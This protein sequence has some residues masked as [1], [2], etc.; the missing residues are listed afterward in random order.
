MDLPGLLCPACGRDYP[1]TDLL[2]RCTCGSVLDV[3]PFAQ[4]LPA[5]AALAGR[6]QSLWRYAEVLPVPV[7]PAVTLQEGM[8]PLIPAPGMPG[9]WI[10]L[11]FLMP[12][13]SFKDRGAAVL[14]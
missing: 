13:L 5:Q 2:W 10:K 14:A 12:T 7:D 1:V 9:A 3:V 11:D 8:T 6:S 4:P